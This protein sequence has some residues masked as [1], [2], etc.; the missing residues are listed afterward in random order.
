MEDA[1]N[2][3]SI[4]ETWI[5]NNLQNQNLYHDMCTQFDVRYRMDLF[6]DMSEHF[7]DD[8][9]ISSELVFY[10]KILIVSLLRINKKYRSYL[11][12]LLVDTDN[13]KCNL[14]LVKEKSIFRCF[15]NEEHLC[16]FKENG[17]DY[18]VS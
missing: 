6:E 11:N 18:Y 5:N 8:S 16:Y 2:N 13:L 12:N 17:N 3:F 7:L 1:K 9:M 15:L 4:F 14:A 10:W